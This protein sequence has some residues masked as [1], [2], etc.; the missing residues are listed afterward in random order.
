MKKLIY[1]VLSIVTLSAVMTSCLNDDEASK[2]SVNYF[3]SCDTVI[4]DVED[5]TIFYWPIVAAL[6]TPET[7]L[8]Y[9]TMVEG[10]SKN[11]F[12]ETASSNQ[13]MTIYAIAKCN[14][15]AMET[16]KGKLAKQKGLAPFKKYIWANYSKS[17][18]KWK[19]SPANESE[20][21]LHGFKVK[22]SLWNYINAAYGKLE[23]YDKTFAAE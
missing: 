2:A 14:E 5:D 12:T 20:I 11:I 8:T 3:G 23:E 19:I 9:S 10:S 1:L 4:F 17:F 16:Y 7:G 18:S 6:A 13:S 15:Q 21:P 22:L